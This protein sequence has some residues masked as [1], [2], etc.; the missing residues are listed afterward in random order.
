MRIR[1]W[2]SDVC[3]YDLRAGGARPLVQER[4]GHV[5]QSQGLAGACRPRAGAVSDRPE[6]RYGNV[7][8][9]QDP[10][11]PRRDLRRLMA[12]SGLA[13]FGA[14]AAA[15][16]LGVV[17]P[18]PD[19]AIVTRSEEHTSELQSLMRISYD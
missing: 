14:V 8:V 5:A 17:S 6:H 3:S 9:G 11:V 4:E 18:G 19:F 12:A 1:D 10:R 16:A 15:H 2:S 7:R 13:V